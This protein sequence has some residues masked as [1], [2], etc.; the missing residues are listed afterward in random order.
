MSNWTHINGLVKVN[1]CKDTQADIDYAV[2]KAIERLPKVTG[3][4]M[5]MTV[6]IVPVD[7][8]T[9]TT[10]DDETDE[11]VQLKQEFY[12]VLRG[13]LRDRVFNETLHELN[14]FMN[15]L[16]KR[17]WVREAL[18]KINTWNKE[19]II[20]DSKFYDSLAFYDYDESIKR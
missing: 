17:I 10:W 3:S 4:E 11:E 5:D 8:V 7:D 2:A 16:A 19:Y 12:L 18:I 9:V 14:K 13:E 6:T 1:S 15:R 20:N